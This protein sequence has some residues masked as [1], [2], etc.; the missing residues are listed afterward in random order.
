MSNTLSGG[1]M[2]NSGLGFLV[3]LLLGFVV[4][5]SAQALPLTTCVDNGDGSHDCTIYESDLAGNPAEVGPIHLLPNVVT[6]GY[7]ILFEDLLTFSPTNPSTWSDVLVFGDDVVDGILQASPAT[8]THMQFLSD[9]CGSNIEGDVSCFPTG[10]EVAGVPHAFLLETIPTFY[11]ASPN[12]YTM[13]S[14]VP[15][16][17]TLLLLAS[18]MLGLLALRRR[19]G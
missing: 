14:E 10:T 9:G 13:F 19:F 7:V 15:E 5:G 8:A 16:P 3:S 11:S 1:Y 12:T 18:S 17:S 2:R 4:C 6:S